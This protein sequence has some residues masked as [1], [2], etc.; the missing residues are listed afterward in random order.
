MPD[1][2]EYLLCDSI[3]VRLDRVGLYCSGEELLKSGRISAWKGC[4]GGR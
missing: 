4:K 1:T 2:K 3:K